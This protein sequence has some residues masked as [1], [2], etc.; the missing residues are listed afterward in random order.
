MVRTSDCSLVIWRSQDGTGCASCLYLKPDDR[1]EVNDVAKQFFE[2]VE[3]LERLLPGIIKAT[4]LPGPLQLPA[5]PAFGL[6]ETDAAAVDST[7]L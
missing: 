5:V 7:E 2:W 1:W 6:Q 3:E 4:S